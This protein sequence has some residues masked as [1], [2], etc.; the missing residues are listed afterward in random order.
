LHGLIIR[1]YICCLPSQFLIKS[2][3]ERVGKDAQGSFVGKIDI[4]IPSIVRTYNSAMGG[5][6]L[7]DQLISYYKTKIRTRR[8]QTRVI[9]HFLNAMVVNAHILYKLRFNLNRGD[10]GYTFLDFMIFVIEDWGTPQVIVQERYAH[11]LP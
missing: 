6:D 11:L 7:M 1:Q 10:K 2:Q 4:D 9:F 8:W 3:V 5:T